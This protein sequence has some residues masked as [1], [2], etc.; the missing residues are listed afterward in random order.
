IGM[1]PA[2]TASVATA[3]AIGGA[4][5]QAIAFEDAM[6]DVKKVVDFDDPDGLKNLSDEILN[7]SKSVPVA[8]DGLAEIA[9]AAGM[10]GIAAGDISAFTE[11][12]A[13]ISIAFGM[14]AEE[15]GEAMA[16]LRTA[17]G[18]TQ[19]EVE[20]LFD[21]TNVL[22]NNFAA[23]ESQ[24]INFAKRV[25]AQATQ[26]G[27]SADQAQAFG[28][29]MI[30]AGSETEVA[31][32]SFRN[33]G[34][35]LTQGVS[36]TKAQRVAFGRLGL[37]A[38]DVAKRMQKDA[39]GTTLDVLERLKELPAELRAATSNQLFG[40]EARAL[41]PLINDTETLTGAIALLG[42]EKARTGS[43][44]RE[45]AARMDTTSTK[46]RLMKNQI[47]AAATAI[48]NAFLPMIADGVAS[49]SAFIA[50]ID[51][52]AFAGRVRAAFEVIGGA[53]NS[54]LQVADQFAK[55]IGFEGIGDAFGS[56]TKL[57]RDSLA[58]VGEYL[59]SFNW[60]GFAEG[61]AAY[62]R[63]AIETFGPL[64][65]SLFAG[66]ANFDLTAITNLANAI[67]NVVS[68][69][70]GFF[71]GFSRGLGFEG[72]VAE[73]LERTIT[74]VGNFI[75]KVG[76]IAGLVFPAGFADGAKKFGEVIGTAFRTAGEAIA[77]VW[78]WIV[79]IA[80]EINILLD[81]I[82]G[83]VDRLANM[84]G[85]LFG[86]ETS[87]VP[88]KSVEPIRRSINAEPLPSVS[89]PQAVAIMDE[90]SQLSSFAM[91]P[92]KAEIEGQAN[93]N[94]NL[95]VTGP[96]EVTSQNAASQGDIKANVGTDMAGAVPAGG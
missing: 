81:R 36:A 16:K 76:E 53:I 80:D 75:E 26:F 78:D 92:Q 11:T 67:Q 6:A 5:H 30:A 27:F 58:T 93:V 64:L 44:D 4:V 57:V 74:L 82:M 7:I 33:M 1:K 77:K 32:T 2:A 73:V 15:S 9:A 87:Q 48:G 29:A 17:L 89:S 24:I 96:A 52:D 90:L 70:V 40:S 20:R 94:V 10:A 55:S 91:H 42:D 37:E 83:P 47:N 22:A 34:R 79:M 65:D 85:G 71:D 49:V 66:L 54:S 18:M 51:M 41:A 69:V 46:M 95:R 35:A 86:E 72:G 50:G 28:T 38:S 62:F 59:S 45:F 14:T 61:G 19:E 88:V 21:G 25:G 43:V 84:V 39:L 68:G 13:K 56:L 63:K 60:G 3:G 23:K 12:A 8:A 31:A